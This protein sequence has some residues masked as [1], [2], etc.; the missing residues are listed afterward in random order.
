MTESETLACEALM[1]GFTVVT[2]AAWIGMFL[3]TFI[4]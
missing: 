3:W 1:S 4:H 2:A